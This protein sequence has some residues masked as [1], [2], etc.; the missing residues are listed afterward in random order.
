MKVR[1]HSIRFDA[2]KKLEMFIQKKL[3]RLEKYYE[4][5][6]DAE[7]ILRVNNSAYENKTVEIK[8]NIPRH[9]LFAKE[10]ASTFET[11]TDLAL[12]VIKRNLLKLKEKLVSH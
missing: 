2:D 9:Q 3:D 1:I 4:R 11:A 5:V 8:L 12:D 6:V 7:V 10:N